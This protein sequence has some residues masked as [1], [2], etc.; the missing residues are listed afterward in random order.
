MQAVVLCL[1][2]SLYAFTACAHSVELT[3]TAPWSSP[4]LTVEFIET[5]AGNNDTLYFS[6]VNDYVHQ[7]VTDL[8]TPEAV[9]K[10][11]VAR[12]QQHTGSKRAVSI[13]KAS[14]A[15]HAAAPRVEAYHQHYREQ[16]GDSDIPCDTW[17]LQD[18]KTPVVCHPSDLIEKVV[19]LSYRP[20]LLLPFDHIMMTHQD[21]HHVA[22]LYTT[23]ITSSTFADF[24]RILSKAVHERPHFAYIIRYKPVSNVS[25]HQAIAGY[26]VEL[27]LKKTDYLVIDDRE[28]KETSVKGK[29]ASIGKKISQ[30]LF[31]DTPSKIEPLS[32]DEIKELG[33]KATQFVQNAKDPMSTLVQLSQDFP[34]YAK[35]VS[36]LTLQKPLVE[37]VIH[38]QGLLRE[39]GLNAFW[40]NGRPIEPEDLDPFSLVRTLK[41]EQELIEIFERIGFTAEQAISVMTDP[42]LAKM[43]SST[44]A[45]EPTDYF[46]VRSEL[47]IWLNNLEKDKRYKSWSKNMMDMLK[48]VYPGQL[49]AIG[50]NIYNLVMVEDLASQDALTRMTQQV[51]DMIKRNT[52][53]RFGVLPVVAKAD[54]PTTAAAIAFSHI[55]QNK[56][57][58][59]SLAF[60]N[61]VLAQ[62]N[63]AKAQHASMDMIKKAFDEVEQD[64]SLQSLLEERQA[65]IEDTQRLL[66][67]LCVT[68]QD[69]VMFLNGKLIEYNNEQVIARDVYFGDLDQD[70]DVYNHI[71]SKPY[72][73]ASRNPYIVVSE[74]RPLVMLP[75]QTGEQDIHYIYDPTAVNTN[76]W[77]IADFDTV[78]GLKLA[79]EALGFLET[80]NSVRLALIHNPSGK[81]T[82]NDIST[83]LYREMLQGNKDFRELI[84]TAIA[85]KDES[86]SE[87]PEQVKVFAP[88]SPAVESF[89]NEAV[90]RQSRV[91]EGLGLS[92]GFQGIVINGRVIGPFE[93]SVTF[94]KEDFGSLLRF[95]NDKR[96][97]PVHAAVQNM[98]FDRPIADILTIVATLIELDK[99]SVKQDAFESPR[100]TIRERPYQEL[101]GN[102]VKITLGDRAGAFVQLGVILDPVS[103]TAQKW[104]SIIETLAGMDGIY[105]EVYLNPKAS[106]DEIPLKR[107]YRYV[108]DREVMFDPATG[109]PTTP[110]AYFADPPADAL[111]TLGMDIVKSWHV[112]VREANV[113][114]DNIQLDDATS[115]Y[116]MYELEYILVEGHCVDSVTRGPPRG[117]QFVLGTQTKPAMTDTIVMANL[118]YF[119]L[120]ARP[121][122]WQLALREGRSTEV[123]HI[124]SVGTQGKWQTSKDG[125]DA[126]KELALTSF[127]GLTV[128]PQVRKNAGMENEDVLTEPSNSKD[129]GGFWSSITDKLFTKKQGAAVQSKQQAD[130]NIFSVASG[131]LYERFMSIMIASV[132]EH[133]NSTVKF[134]FIENFLSPTFKDF[135][136]HMAQEYGFDYEMVT[137]KWPSWLRAQKEKQRT[138]WGYKILFLDVL[139]PLDLD[140]VIF[141]DADQVVRTDMKE[142]VD[143]D[144]HGAPYGYTPFCKDRTEMDGFRFW[145][146]GYWRD[147][148][149]GKPYH[150]SALYVIDLVRFRQL[151][152]GDRL[153]AQYQQLS[154]DPNSLANLDQDLPNNMQHIVPIHSLPQEWLWCETWCSDESLSKAKTI[155]LCN[156][157]LTKEPKLDRARRQLPEWEVY[158]QQVEALRDR[159][160]AGKQ[161]KDEGHV[162]SNSKPEHAEL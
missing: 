114:L 124:E 83:V 76:L 142:L 139:F 52:P 130:I 18:L 43:E 58:L 1:F 38:N 125:S 99:G 36:G 3:L 158:D 44:S 33:L 62:L 30:T 133:T 42:A 150:I 92:D 134:W 110:A 105:A 59:D 118:G 100:P 51:V 27:A 73:S 102:H 37:E 56:S 20:D 159:I 65:F 16:Y 78:P 57:R 61:N 31:E 49:R 115:V 116:T 40:L 84:D 152:A 24:H 55:Q 121:G 156:N 12:A 144:L 103:E 53:I 64:L 2:A 60:L 113:D 141:V 96:I 15:I 111:Y 120:K 153:R 145:N 91:L 77:V 14:F 82:L 26:G 85:T 122:V 17:V 162:E 69:S 4:P 95:E 119:Q 23:D 129:E 6:L 63:E 88:G 148:L 13:A 5:V 71:M 106:L 161:V 81:A 89:A 47:V 101:Q 41:T 25:H 98:T 154:A 151:A 90:H 72:V 46:D 146:Q 28:N 45:R 97:Q 32:K 128:Y 39:S 48:P 157:P 137:Y 29:L 68:S 54:S 104:S 112:T 147:H 117:L 94:T 127:E 138:I 108:F 86:L 87:T 22:I 9:Y 155:D 70:E 109:A 34:R 132:M 135:I 75:L 7:P 136:P 19:G 126:H 140:K 66:A 149:R 50:R 80:D 10:D 160:H 21:V 143:L 67:R 131:H 8:N 35:S 123:Y 79:S 74:H 107:F 11:A 93:E